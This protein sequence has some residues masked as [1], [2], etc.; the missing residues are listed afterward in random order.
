MDDYDKKLLSE[1]KSLIFKVFESNY[2]PTSKE[3]KTLESIIN[4]IEKLLEE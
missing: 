2:W 4:K 3:S 1:A